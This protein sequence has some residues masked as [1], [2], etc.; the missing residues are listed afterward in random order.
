M[1]KGAERRSWFARRE[2][3]RRSAARHLIICAVWVA[4]LLGI[5]AA[6]AVDTFSLR[7]SLYYS[8]VEAD[9]HP[10]EDAQF[11]DIKGNVLAAGSRQFVEAASI[12]GTAELA[13]GTILNFDR[14]IRGE[15][16]WRRVSA[17]HGI[18]ARGCALVPFRSA[19]VDP[20]LVPLG[21]RLL[22]AE[23]RG[24]RL[25]GGGTHDGIWVA[26]DTGEKIKGR[27]IDLFTGRGKASMA[28]I[29]KVGIDYLDPV[30]VRVVGRGASCPQRH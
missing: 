1:R 15:V 17:P 18:D 10:G 7:S 14:I 9:Y 29:E 16:R 28:T 11:R 12:E 23:T 22:I 30:Q 26:T 24:I 3:T 13:D 5:G 2:S 8:A 4:P 19:A 21:S 6:G 27:R 20:D 25:P